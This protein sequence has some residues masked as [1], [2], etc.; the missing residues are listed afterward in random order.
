[1]QDA[2]H[3]RSEASTGLPPADALAA[4]EPVVNAMSIDVEEY[5]H[6]SAL[7]SVAPRERWDSL[8]SRVVE[9][10]HR[11]L[12]L[13]AE[14]GARATFFTLGCVAERYPFLV[15]EMAAAGHEVASHGFWHYRVGQQSPDAFL[16]D[17][18]RTKKLLEDISG[19]EVTGYRAANFSVDGDCWWAFERLAEAG[20]RYSSS[21]NP[22]LHDHYGV[23]GAP[24]SPFRPGRRDI[25]E[26][27]LTTVEIGGRRLPAA[28]GGY[29]RLLPYALSRT[30]MRR[31]NRRERR[32]VFFYFHPWEI[33][34]GQPRLPARGRSRFRHYVNLGVMEAK[35]ARLLRDFRWDRTDRVYGALWTPAGLGRCAQWSPSGGPRTPI[36]GTEFSDSSGGAFRTDTAGIAGHTG[37]GRAGV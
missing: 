5:F 22:V 34:P 16:A 2:P 33:D 3:L 12:S 7:G 6:A 26:L 19:Q 32:P 14:A 15:R 30:A 27:P 11:T 36:G 24:R 21:V 25:V 9:T 10:T 18:V 23:P 17:V 13:L 4:G 1:M 35:L 8:E 20:Y 28:G 37:S 29:F 31:V